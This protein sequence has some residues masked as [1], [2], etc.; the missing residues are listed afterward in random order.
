MLL[1]SIPECD[2][3]SEVPVGASQEPL[4]ALEMSTH[5]P[6]P[7]GVSA[8]GDNPTSP[9][10]QGRPPE[11]PGR[12]ILR[13]CKTRRN[14]TGAS[15][16]QIRRD[17]ARGWQLTLTSQ[18][19]ESLSVIE[20]VERQLDDVSPTA[21]R[22]LRTATQLLR[23]AG[24]A[25]RDDSLAALAMAVSHLKESGTD[26]DHHAVSTLCRLGF[27]HLGKFD[28]FYSLPRHQ[29]RLRWSKSAAAS[30]MLDLSMEASVAL[31]HLHMS[32]AKRLASDALNISETVRK[33]AGGLAALPACIA[34]QVLYEEGCLD[35]AEMMVRDRLPAINAEGPIECALRAYLVL[36]RVARQRMQHEF[37]ALLVSEGE[38]LGKRRGWPRLVAACLA[39]RTSLLLHTRRMKEARMSFE[40]LDHHAETHRGGSGHLGAEVMRYR[41]LTRWRLSWAETPSSEAVAA[42][43]QLY[44]R[45][46]EKRDFYLACGLAVELAEML[47][48]IGE[49]EEADALFFHTIKVGAAAG[50]YQVFLEGEAGLGTLLRRAYSRSEELASTDR[51]VLPFV[52]SLLSRWEARRAGDRSVQPGGRVSDALTARER[53]IVAMISQGLSNKSIART[54]KISPETVKSHVKRIF[55]K[56]GVSTRS[57]AVSRAGSLG[58]L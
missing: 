13:R 43:R 18:I 54:L 53:D 7:F 24:L 41:T 9:S 16:V 6:T 30:A 35:Q 34:A 14:L 38:A 51:D 33:D 47:T 22:S 56:L 8:T 32:T 46:L 45:S 58:L 57:E 26:Q 12:E 3:E 10:E 1:L 27:W 25:F 55:S 11:E 40:Q 39:E 48:V 42:L 28:L 36:A 50:L 31:D 17:L 5:V 29:P 21:A 23:A 4:V 2:D 49:S 44:H 15:L 19:R 37:A 20:R 52:G